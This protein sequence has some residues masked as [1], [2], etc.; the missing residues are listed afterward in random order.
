[1]PRRARATPRELAPAWPDGP[2]N[3][4]EGEVARRFAE[5][6][7]AVIG[8]RAVRAV[9]RD[10]GVN[11]STLLGILDGQKWP[12][13]ETIAKIEEGTGTDL[14][15]GRLGHPEVTKT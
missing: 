11:H 7:R 14:W 9:A 1:M 3:S 5:N 12:D 2:A 8:T 13:L 4:V 10:A 15:P 6:L